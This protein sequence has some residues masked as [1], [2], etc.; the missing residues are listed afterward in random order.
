MLDDAPSTLI[1][2]PSAALSP[3]EAVGG[4][5]NSG[6]DDAAAEAQRAYNREAAKRSRAKKKGQP[7]P[8]PAAREPAP[9]AVTV[10]VPKAPTFKRP[11]VRFKA[12][13]EA[14]PSVIEVEACTL[15]SLLTGAA[16]SIASITKDGRVLLLGT[17]KMPGT[18]RTMA[19]DLGHHCDNVLAMHG[20]ALTPEQTVYA[21]LI[22]SVGIIASVFSQ[23]PAMMT[24][25]QAQ[26]AAPEI[27]KA[28]DVALGPM[29][30]GSH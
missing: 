16:G 7:V 24:L 30:G 28:F 6:P 9:A 1:G 8:A 20:L 18:Q 17:L 25:E 12:G 2:L 5:V 11:T 19:G 23:L 22:V 26:G 27:Q 15:E 3:G 13:R 21:N 10:E 29:M 14:I 4:P